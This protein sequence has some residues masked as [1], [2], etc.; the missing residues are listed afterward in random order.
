M[1]RELGKKIRSLCDELGTS[2]ASAACEEFT[3]DLE[4]EYDKRV[5]AGMSEIDAYRD[6]LKNIDEIKKI[7]A[8]LPKTEAETEEAQRK[9]DQKNLKNILSKISTCMWLILVIAYFAISLSYGHWG[10]T[11]LIF[12][13]GSMGQTVLDMIL[14]YNKGKPL[15]KVLKSGVTSIVWLFTVILYFAVS[16]AIGHWHLTWLIFLVGILV[17]KIVGWIFE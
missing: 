10:T 11:W 8:T 2:A 6:V 12:L 5:D 17:Q 13:W 1:K 15:N 16:F 7:L 4:T 3:R 9:T 14:K